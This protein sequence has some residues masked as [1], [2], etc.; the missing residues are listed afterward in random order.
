MNKRNLVVVWVDLAD[1]FGSVKHQLIFFAMEYFGISK[2]VIDFFKFYYSK[3]RVQIRV[4]DELTEPVDFESGVFQRCVVSPTLFNLVFQLLAATLACSKEEAYRF[5]L[6]NA[7]E[8]IDLLLAAFADDLQIT[9]STKAG[10]KVLIKQ[11]SR[12]L[13]WSKGMRAKPQ[14][15]VAH[16]FENDK[17]CNPNIEI[18]GRAIQNL[19]LSKLTWSLMIHELSLA[20]AKKLDRIM[21]PYLKKWWRFVRSANEV[22]LFSG[23][24]KTV[25]PR[26]K[27]VQTL[28]K[29]GQSIKL[30][31]LR[32][33]SNSDIV[34]LIG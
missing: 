11:L 24:K 29:Q 31:L 21:L 27:R 13:S 28:F 4:K 9:I 3:L 19:L 25:R 5:S 33:S 1:A 32:T 12:F 23:S 7:E 6:K 8:K 26:H 2:S 34:K 30:D 16:S 10:S 18:D 17:P 15:C 22:I 20:F 14:K